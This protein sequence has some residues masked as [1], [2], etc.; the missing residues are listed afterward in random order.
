MSRNAG[1]LL[2]NYFNKLFM[3]KEKKVINVWTVFLISRKS[4]IK[5]FLK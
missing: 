1:Y 4:T 5:T 2:E 3:R